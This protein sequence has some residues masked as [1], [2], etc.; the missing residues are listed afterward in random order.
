MIHGAERGVAYGPINIA[1]V[2][3]LQEKIYLHTVIQERIFDAKKKKLLLESL[4]ILH[5]DLSLPLQTLTHTDTHTH[6][7]CP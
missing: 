7:V 4:A 6:N 1:C 3:V 2:R 5:P